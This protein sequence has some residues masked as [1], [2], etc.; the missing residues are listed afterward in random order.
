MEENLFDGP[1]T[2]PAMAYYQ[3]ELQNDSLIDKRFWIGSVILDDAYLSGNKG[4]VNIP[5]DI[6]V[7]AELPTFE[8]AI[9][10]VVTSPIAPIS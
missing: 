5:E 8:Y 4:R 2:P 9:L 3:L 7:S 1:D 6:C 10:K